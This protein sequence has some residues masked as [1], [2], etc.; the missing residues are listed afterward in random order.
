MDTRAES[1]GMLGHDRSQ[2][3]GPVALCEC[4]IAVKMSANEGASP[5]SG[6][7]DA[8]PRLLYVP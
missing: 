8:A 2:V 4:P 5:A 3:A 6:G 1:P 7:N